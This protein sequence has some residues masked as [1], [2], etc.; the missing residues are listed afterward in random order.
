[1]C[2]DDITLKKIK[3]ISL[4]YGLDFYETKAG[5]LISNEAREY[6]LL[7]IKNGNVTRLWHQNHGRSGKYVSLP[8]PVEDVTNDI[9]H[10][11]FHAQSW[12]DTD[13]KKTLVY[14]YHHGNKRKELDFQR[15]SIINQI[16]A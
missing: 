15:K 9:V 1:M 11:H 3:D 14:V 8:C 4:Y 13:I 2:V 6:F 5:L 12:V 7:K 16:F 10:S